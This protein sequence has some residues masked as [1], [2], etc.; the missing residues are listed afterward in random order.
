MT[1]KFPSD[2][3]PIALCMAKLNVLV[4]GN[5]KIGKRKALAYSKLGAK[6]H[7][8]DPEATQEANFVM[9]FNTYL[10]QHNAHF[11]S[12]H[13]VIIATNSQE[14][15]EAVE[16]VCEAQFK[17]FNRTDDASRGN[18]QDLSTH[19]T[20]QYFIAV[21]SGGNAPKIGQ[22]VLSTIQDGKR[23]DE[24]TVQSLIHAH[25]KADHE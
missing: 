4:V 1:H 15:N 16:I 20:P 10:E 13:L 21:G 3:K 25:R 23:V 22:Y 19:Y 14:T 2:Y 6:V 18:F 24:A 5:G 11:Q 7:A 12:Q 8:I 9:S 17:L